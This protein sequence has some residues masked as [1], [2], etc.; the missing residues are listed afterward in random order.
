ML[1]SPRLTEHPKH[2]GRAARAACLRGPHAW[3]PVA[4]CVVCACIHVCAW[5]L[6]VSLGCHLSVSGTLFQ[7]AWDLEPVFQDEVS[8]LTGVHHHSQIFNGCWK[9]KLRFSRLLAKTYCLSSPLLAAFLGRCPVTEL[10][11]REL[12]WSVP[13]PKFR[14]C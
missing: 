5:H 10:C 4:H 12:S 14:V 8:G 7:T 6:E 13:F 2:T 9:I 11:C 3:P 1:A